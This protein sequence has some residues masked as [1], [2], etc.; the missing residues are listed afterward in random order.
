MP[1]LEE[2]ADFEIIREIG[3][4]GMST[5]YLAEDTKLNRLV[6]LKI[7]PEGHAANPM[8]RARFEQEARNVARL[9]HPGI[10]QVYQVGQARGLHYLAMEFVDGMTLAGRML[11]VRREPG[12]LK[13]GAYLRTQAQLIADVADALEHAHEHDIIHRD[14]KPSN[15]LV[16]RDGR[17][18]LADFGIAKDL[19]DD[20][21]TMTGQ[22]SGTV[23]YMS[24]EQA[25]MV[26]TI[27]RRTDIFSLGTVL[28]E[29]LTDALPFEGDS[30]QDI[31]YR[32]GN[33]EPA[34]IRQVNPGVPRDLETICV[35]ALEKRPQDRYQSASQMAADLR[36][37]MRG[38][39]ILARPPSVVRRTRRWVGR[40][41]LAAL[42]TVIIVLSAV[43]GLLGY[44]VR[45]AARAWQAELVVDGPVGAEIFLTPFDV[46][47]QDLGE[48]EHIGRAPLVG[49]WLPPG[50][51]RI[52]VVG[53]GEAFGEYTVEAEPGDVLD[54]SVQAVASARVVGDM[55]LVDQTSHQLGIPGDA[56]PWNAMRT[57]TLPPFYIDT[58]EVSNGEYR[59]FFEAKA[60]HASLRPRQWQKGFGYDPTLDAL[61]VVGVTQEQARQ[62]AAWAGKRLPTAAEWEAAARA[63]D[64]RIYPWGND[65]REQAVVPFETDETDIERAMY[66][67]Y[68]ARARPVDSDGSLV[69]AIGLH[70]MLGNVREWV[71]N[72]DFAAGNVPKF[73]G[74][75]WQQTAIPPD[76][77]S[78]RSS[79]R[80]KPSHQIGF[81]C[82]RSATP[83][84]LRP[85]R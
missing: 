43:V 19:S 2:I 81:R 56:L 37:F 58:T 82:A 1:R 18:R 60:R 79:P 14:V 38:D 31:L 44:Q 65:A 24:P 15:I 10:V 61:P 34:R 30:A 25:A 71:D 85:A 75:S 57:V 59:A 5:V 6:A 20:G 17:P 62:Y 76:F 77:R 27:D 8:R 13:T 47:T 49:H 40:H 74:M 21:L 4:G 50:L 80:G 72:I 48:P 7:L 55:R 67:E 78:A 51:Y 54:V 41:R 45:Q 83:P 39:P 63:P 52:T 16:E 12:I 32:I 11:D 36:C 23:P 33:R 46:E 73:R 3:R 42:L 35:K 22:L 66:L 69:N 9:R 64:G 28:Y 68:R 53:E 29:L 84:S 70:H 26:K